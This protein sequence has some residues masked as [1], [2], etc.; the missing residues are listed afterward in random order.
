MY[1]I[2]LSFFN[3]SY[4]S[5]D[6]IEEKCN[7]TYHHM[8]VE[9]ADASAT[10]CADCESKMLNTPKDDRNIIISKSKGVL[11]EHFCV[12]PPSYHSN[13]QIGD[14][15]VFRVDDFQE[16]SKVVEVGEIVKFRRSKAGKSRETLPSFVRK[17]NEYDDE[18]LNRNKK[19][20]ERAKPFFY[21]MTEKYSLEMKLVDVHFQFD[22]KKLYF[23]YTA[24]GRVDFRQLAKSL[25]SEFK[26]RIEL[27]QIGVRDEAKII[28]GIGTCG[29]E[30]CCSSF[31]NSFKHISTQYAS[32][33]HL[34][35]RLTKL[36]GPCGKLKCCLSFELDK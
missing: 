16:I 27:R 19:D 31:M 20:E 11:G 32:D 15:I 17:I 18:K 2:D 29:R 10:I 12:I 6:V 14:R 8:I 33:Q 36:S 26:T 28:G 24:D 13:V 22:R 4:D 34:S 25:A 30:S 35:T 9:A 1:N 3:S 5:V 21:K 23:F 7:E